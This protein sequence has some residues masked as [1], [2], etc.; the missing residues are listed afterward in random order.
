MFLWDKPAG[1]KAFGTS[2]EFAAASKALAAN[3]CLYGAVTAS[4]KIPCE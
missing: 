4:K 3:R 1:L 2:K